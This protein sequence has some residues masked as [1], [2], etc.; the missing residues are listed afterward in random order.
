LENETELITEIKNIVCRLEAG[1]QLNGFGIWLLEQIFETCPNSAVA[2]SLAKLDLVEDLL[3]I[4]LE[5]PVHDKCFML[6]L[7]F[8]LAKYIKL[9]QVYEIGKITIFILI[10]FKI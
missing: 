5:H 3:R 2:A 6:I 7:N 10:R 9:S 4:G 8:F 1:F